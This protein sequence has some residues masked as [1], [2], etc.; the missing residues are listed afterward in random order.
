MSASLKFRLTI[1]SVLVLATCCFAQNGSY[2]AGDKIKD[3][4]IQLLNHKHVKLSQINR[5]KFLIIDFWGIWCKP[6][7]E[8]L[9][10]LDSLKRVFKDQLEVIAIN[11]GDSEKAIDKFLKG[12]ERLKNL[13]ILIATDT[14]NS[15]KKDLSI[16]MY[17]S[18][19]W[20]DTA[21]I[22]RGKMDGKDLSYENVHAFISEGAVP[23]KYNIVPLKVN[24]TKGPFPTNDTGFLYRSFLEKANMNV[25]AAY[26]TGASENI[27]R[28]YFSKASIQ[29]LYFFAAFG[30]SIPRSQKSRF[31]LETPDS[32]RYIRPKV[33]DPAF[34]TAGYKSLTDWEREHSYIYELIL[35][36]P[37]RKDSI[38]N[39]YMLEDLNRFFDV[40][41]SIEYRDMPCYLI[42]NK[43]EESKHLSSSG[44]ASKWIINQS[45]ANGITATKIIGIQ[46]KT[47]NDF[48]E[49]LCSI[50]TSMPFT[51]G[52]S[53]TSPVDLTCDFPNET[54]RIDIEKL[55][56][57]LSKQGFDIVVGTGKVKVLV[58]SNK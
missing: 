30:Y 13:S 21:R 18:E 52:T 43:T 36:K 25:K 37:V 51:N 9:P 54:G 28:V 20:I 45:S 7:V 53:N 5:G 46:N 2:K 42:V 55:R 6:C 56:D 12:N 8:G 41:G 38:L 22:L 26:Y 4:T 24:V 32:I 16:E 35:P 15:L 57:S 1:I 3:Y 10:R 11:S 33:S 17:P 27:K 49:K 23:G 39:L 19:F 31:V 40:R 48:A 58:L 47:L 34:L 44:G 29:D 50:D 14:G